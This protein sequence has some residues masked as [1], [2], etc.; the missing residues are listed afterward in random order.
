VRAERALRLLRKSADRPEPRVALADFERIVQAKSAA[1]VVEAAGLWCDVI[2]R[3]TAEAPSWSRWLPPGLRARLWPAASVVVERG[4]V[5]ASAKALLATPFGAG[6]T[7]AARTAALSRCA[8]CSAGPDWAVW[9]L[10]WPAPGGMKAGRR[11]LPRLL[12][13]CARCGEAWESP[14]RGG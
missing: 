10:A 11:K 13:R 2:E 1:C 3:R 14:G 9:H 4:D 8:A 5:L 7:Q 12:R 6:L